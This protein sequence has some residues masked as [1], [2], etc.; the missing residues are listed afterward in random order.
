M[1]VFP[2]SKRTGTPAATM[3]NQVPEIVKKQRVH[4]MQKMADEKAAAFHEGFIGSD[5]SVL[6]EANHDGIFDGLTG[7]YIRVYVKDKAECGEIYQVHIE[8]MYR[9]GLWGKIC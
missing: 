9:D 3:K 7:N 4:L 1:H 8:K 6:F 5:V 2:Y